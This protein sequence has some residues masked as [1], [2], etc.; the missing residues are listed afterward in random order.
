MDLKW[1]MA[2]LT[3]RARRFLQRTGRNLGANGPTSMG[4]DMSKMECYNCHRKGHF[5]RECR[6]PKDSRRNGAAEPQRWNVPVE[7]TTSNA[8]VSQC[9]GVGSYD[10]SFQAE[11]EPTNYALMAFS[12]SSSSSGN[13]VVSCSKACTKAYAQLQSH[14]DKLTADFQKS[15]FDVI[16]Y[17]TGLESVE[18]RLLVYQQNESVFEEDIKLLKLEVQLRDNALV[19]LGQN[20]E[21]AKQKRDDLKL[22]LEKFQTS[23][24]NLTELLAS[25]T[26]AKTGLGYNSQV[27]TR[28]MFDCDDYLSSGSDESLPPSPI[29]DRYQSGNGY[30]AVPPA[31]T[32]TFMPPKPDLVFNNA[33]NAVETDYPTFN[34]KLSP[35]KPNQDLSHTNRP[36][37]PIIEDWVSGLEDESETKALQNVLSFIQPTEH[38]KSPRHSVQHVETSIPSASSKTAIPKPTSNGKRRN[39]KACFIPVSTGVPKT[40]VTG[41]KQVKHIVTKPNSPTKRHINRSPSPK[42]SNSPPRITTVKAPVVTAAQ[43]SNGLGLKEKLNILIFVQGNPQHALKDKG[44]IDSGCSRHMTRNM[45]YLSDFEELNGGYVSFRGNPK[46]GKIFGKGTIRIRKLDFDDVYFVKELKFNFFSVS[47]MCDKKNSVLF[48][49]TE[50]LVLSPEFKLPDESQVLLRNTDGDA[51]FHEKK[52]E[53]DAKKPESEVDVSPSSSAQSKKHDDKTKREAKGKSPVKSFMGFRNLSAEF[54][55]FFDNS[56]NEVNAVGTLV[57]TVGQISLTSTNTFSAAGLSNAAASPTHRKSTCIDAFQLPDDP[58]MPELEDITYSDDEDDV[59]AKADFNNLETSITVS[60]IPTTRVHKDHHVTQIIGD[61][62]SATQTRSMTRVAKDQGRL[63]QMFNDDFHTCMFACFLSQEEPKRIYVDGIIFG[64]INKDLCKSF[65]KLIKDK[66]QMSLMGELRFF[67]GLQVKQKKDGI[68]ISQDKYVAEILRKFRLTDGK[69]A[70]TPI[71]TK[72]PLLKDPD[73]KDVDVHTYRSMIGSLVYLTLSRPDIMFAIYACARFEV[74]PKAS[75]LHAV[76]WIFR[77]LKGKP[78]LGLCFGLTLQIVL[79]SMESLKRMVHVTN[80]LSAG[81][82]SIPQMVLNSPCLTHIENWLVQI[83]RSLQFWATVAVK[84]VNDVTRLQALVDK[85]KVVVTEATIRVALRLDDAEGVECLPNDEIFA[86]LA[87]MG[88]EKPSTKLTFYKAFFSSQ[89][90]VLNHT[91]LQCMSAKRPSWNEFSSSMASAV[92]CLSSGKGFSRVETPL[93]ERMMVAQ[94]VNEG[95][96]DEVHD[97]GVPTAGVA[98]EGV[99]S[100]ADDVVPTA[101]EEPSIPSPTPPTPPPQPSQDIPS[102]SQDAGIPMNH[103]QDVMDTC[104]TLTRRVDHLKLDKIAQALEITQLKRR[105]KKL[106]RRNKVKVLK[107]RRLQKVGIAQRIDTSDDTLMD[108]VSN[109]GRMIADMDADANVVLEEAKDVAADA[110]DD[111]DAD[112]LSMQEEESEPAKLQEVMDIVTTAKIITKVVTAASTTITVADVPIHVL[113][114]VATTAVA[115]KLTDAPS[116]RTKGVVIRDPEES[117]TTTSTIIHS[118]AKSRDKGKGILVEEPKP[119]KKQAQIEQDEN[120]ARELEVEL[121]RNINWDEVIDHVNKKAKEDKSVKRYQAMKRK[122]QTE[123]QARKNMMVY[124]KNV[125]GFK[126][127][128]FKGMSYN[129]IRPVF[130]RYFDSNMAFLQ[131]T[132][133]QIDEEESRALKKINET[134]AEKATKRQKLKEEVKELKRHLQ[135]VPNEDNDVYT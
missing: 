68:F 101:D 89:W 84:K 100:A 32:G 55:D 93:F 117:T 98:N 65:E 11:E 111:Q 13:E 122:P 72:K 51:A 2:M 116:R 25:Q 88:Y 103:L 28:A 127:D 97:E 36:S 118:E 126:M 5:A 128:Y 41:P 73:G 76:K 24:K 40:R 115:P 27:F 113:I 130:E 129:D 96:A 12:F 121:N 29:Y 19:N 7:T 87:K 81:Y 105:V 4:F 53:F 62:S 94:E 31:Y 90:K 102:T 8:L 78:H 17:Q 99:I 38:V 34:V 69:S 35:T 39:R 79:S 45:S 108:D 95:V 54:N 59:G 107:L 47:Q 132:K 86:E 22:K 75:H 135:I 92:I 42:A 50:C 123:A 124:L 20:L 61:L 120:Y 85:K 125:A 80:I 15:Q 46:G 91:I 64:S 44:V 60:P 52:H 30:H 133:E 74:T 119:L 67:L 14:Y 82:L 26:N 16:S 114:Y 49:N 104:T 63:S 131:K 9:D 23:S 109:Q 21:K 77:Y 112:V 83:K 71:D 1:Q 18:A 134:P 10:W 33:P 70:S 43:V 110:K 37:A 57:P 106:D 56:I 6:S 66:F 58:D 3:M 48:T